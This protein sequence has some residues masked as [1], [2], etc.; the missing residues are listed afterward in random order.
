MNARDA[1]FASNSESVANESPAS[2]T[3]TATLNVPADRT[4]TASSATDDAR[5]LDKSKEQVI[6]LNVSGE[7]SLPAKSRIEIEVTTD[8]ERGQEKVLGNDLKASSSTKLIDNNNGKVYKSVIDISG[9]KAGLQKEMIVSP[10][11][12][13]GSE[14]TIKPMHRFTTYNLFVGDELVS[15]QKVMETFIPASPVLK[16]KPIEN[17]LTVERKSDGQVVESFVKANRDLNVASRNWNSV[18]KFELEDKS[19]RLVD[20]TGRI[21][22]ERFRD[23]AT[24]QG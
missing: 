18:Y 4:V 12:V 10:N 15:T 20:S 22:Y 5:L 3:I 11:S 23:D 8:I 17:R 6:N 13:M 2:K 7:G 14:V 19:A 21:D 16:L 9:F 1:V 24:N